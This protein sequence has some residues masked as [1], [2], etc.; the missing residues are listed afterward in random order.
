MVAK[1]AILAMAQKLLDFSRAIC[2][3]HCCD[4]RSWQI[5]DEEG[6]KQGEGVGWQGQCRCPGVGHYYVLLQG[7]STSLA[8]ASIQPRS[9]SVMAEGYFRRCKLKPSLPG[10]IQSERV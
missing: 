4:N 9:T 6:Q 3:G 1:A 2:L 8:A 10:P 5:G 7:E